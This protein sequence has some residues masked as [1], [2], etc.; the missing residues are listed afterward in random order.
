MSTGASQDIGEIVRLTS[1][2]FCSAIYFPLCVVFMA[3]TQGIKLGP[4]DYVII[5]LLSTLASIGTTP[6]PSSSL[7]LT[8]MIAGSVNVPVT[9]MYVR[10]DPV[11]CCLSLVRLMLTVSQGVI[12]AI[13]WFLD[14]F[15][16]AVNVSGDMFA[17]R[18]VEKMTGIKD[19]PEE[20]SSEEEGH[21][22]SQVQENTQRV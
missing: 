13:D 6:I 14:R 8:V 4:T 19:D 5:C 21:V 11:R 2:A 1:T 9:G 16:T 7:V 3:V 17:A 22:S 10:F 15:R 20:Y 18:V 12:V